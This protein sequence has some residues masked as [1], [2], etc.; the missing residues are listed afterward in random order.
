[1][2]RRPDTCRPGGL[3]GSS[4]ALLSLLT[5]SACERLEVTAFRVDRGRVESTVTSIEAGV[6]EPLAKASLAAA[7]SGRIVR[8]HAREGERVEAGVVLVELENDLEK[9]EVEESLR[10]L[11]RLRNLNDI[12]SKERLEHA[13]YVHRRAQVRHEQTLIRA[14]FGGLVAKV[15]AR[16]GEVTYGSLPLAMGTDARP[17]PLV[18]LVNDSR[19][20]VKAFIDEAD[21]GAVD[22]GQPARVTLEGRRENA[23][24]GRVSF[25]AAVV[26]TEEGETRSVEVQVEV[27]SGRVTAPRRAASGAVE[28]GDVGAPGNGGGAPE[29]GGSREAVLPRHDL[30]I[31]MSVDLEILVDRIEDAVRVP[32]MVI[33]ER[34]ADKYVHVIEAGRLRRRSVTTGAGNWEWTEVTSGLTPGDLVILPTESKLLREGLKVNATLSEKG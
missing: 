34:G 19:L 30:L 21:A 9:L 14:P 5:A 4:L 3:S 16:V 11:G 10:E 24:E 27:P 2:S 18:Y 20:L 12:E 13:E 17:Q 33:L 6:I 8:V 23:L 26:S 28:G 32:T 22:P 25:I 1:M 7:N 15:N 31:G 29:N